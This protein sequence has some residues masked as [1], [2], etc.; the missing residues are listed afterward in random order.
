LRRAAIR[1]GIVSMTCV[2]E[3]SEAENLAIPI[4]H[5]EGDLAPVVPVAWAVSAEKASDRI[6]ERRIVAT[7]RT[8]LALLPT[9]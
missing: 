4:I 6:A 2:M 8:D 9:L 7:E 3:S 5:A 1:R